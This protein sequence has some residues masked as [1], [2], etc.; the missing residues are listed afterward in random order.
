MRLTDEQKNIINLMIKMGIVGTV[1]SIPIALWAIPRWAEKPI[2]PALILTGVGL[3]IKEV[4]ISHAEHTPP[5]EDELVAAPVRVN[6]TAG[7]GCSC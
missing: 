1:V 3:A 2:I 4:M 5:L 6:P 7:C